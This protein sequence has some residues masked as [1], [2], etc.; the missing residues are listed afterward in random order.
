MLRYSP[1][2]TGVA[3]LPMM[4]AI[5][6]VA[7]VPQG[8]LLKHLTMRAIVAAG[9]IASGA[10][11][12]LLT[13]AGAGSPYAAWVLPGLVLV[14]TG[15]GSAAVVAVAVGQQGVE[16]RDADL[17]RASPRRNP[18]APRSRPARAP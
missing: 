5:G 2:M 11:A 3:F 10:G 16:P 6:V 18:P 14:G 8:V 13:Q 1:I 4:V 7:T 15:I 9:L 17:R 12:A